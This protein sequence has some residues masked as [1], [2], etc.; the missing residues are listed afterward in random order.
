[1]SSELKKTDVNHTL[2][3]KHSKHQPKWQ[4]KVN[5]FCKRSQVKAHVFPTTSAGLFRANPLGPR[6]RGLPPLCPQLCLVQATLMGQLCLLQ[7][8]LCLQQ[9]ALKLQALQ[10]SN[11]EVVPSAGKPSQTLCWAS[12]LAPGWSLSK[13]SSRLSIMWLITTALFN[14]HWAATAAAIAAAIAAVVTR[15]T[16]S[17]ITGW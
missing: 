1:M 15:G 3:V 6:F 14:I 8:T 9:A 7:A 5:P 2:G 12:C 17:S 4:H 10:G 13:S 11:S 16:V